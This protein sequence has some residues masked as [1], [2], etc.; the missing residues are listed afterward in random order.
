M[1]GNPKQVIQWLFTQDRDKRFEIKEYKEKRSLN[2]NS[3]L[4]KLCTMIA[5][6]LRTEKESV[7]LEMLKS[8]GQSDLVSVRADINPVGLFK[9]Y[10]QAGQST[11][12]GKLFTHY[13][14]YRGSSEYDTREMSVLLDGV[15]SEAKAL[16]IETA[17]PA[18]LARLKDGWQ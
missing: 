18:E 10:E 14:V 15:I 4:W 7:Y 9:Y 3:Y 11:L 13:R 17:T 2:A 16:D 5:D 6:V 1:I 8:Y 12:N